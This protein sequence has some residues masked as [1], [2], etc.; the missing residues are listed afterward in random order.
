MGWEIDN[1]VETPDTAMIAFA[2]SNPDN[3]MPGGWMQID[4]LW[5][6][7]IADTIPNADFERWE[8]NSYQ[9]PVNW[10]TANIFSALFG[11]DA[12][13]TPSTDAHSGSY[14]LRIESVETM[15]PSEDGFSNAVVGFGMPYS[16]SFF[17]GESMPTFSVDFNPSGL[18]GYYKFD[19]MIDDTAMIMV[20]LT[21]SEENSYYGGTLLTASDTYTSFTVG[22]MIPTNVDITEVGMVVS[23][24]T[25][26]MQGDG[27]S[28]DVGS[29]LLLD[30]LELINPCDGNTFAIYSV[31]SPTCDNDTAVID[32]GSGWDEYLWSNG[33]TSQSIS[34]VI[35]D[36]ATYSVTVTDNATGCEYSDEVDIT[37]PICDAIDHN[38]GYQTSVDI[39][40]NPSS[41]LISL[42]FHNHL[43][44]EFVAEI[45]AV[46]GKTLKKETL[47]ISQTGNEARLD[48]SDCPSGLYLIKITG[49]NFNHCERIMIN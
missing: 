15:I 16:G 32:A 5:F 41:G 45:I 30:D 13:A 37:L 21:D 39:F 6:G 28:G 49:N 2:C 35:T 12:S 14:S 26:F 19:P 40:P 20:I 29:I 11:G 36:A 1:M 3:P 33:A 9:E 42:A 43:S 8:T 10:V 48:L 31:I 24:S 47:S 27:Q 46:T 17:F 4:S 23:T 25:Y 34:V 18:R 38:D 22:F 44:G 7:G